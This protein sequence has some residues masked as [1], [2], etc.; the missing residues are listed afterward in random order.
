MKLEVNKDHKKIDLKNLKLPIKKV[1]A[2]AGTVLCLFTAAF[3]KEV[4][5]EDVISNS[6]VDVLISE[7][8][9]SNIEDSAR[10]YNDFEINDEVANEDLQRLKVLDLTIDKENKDL[11]FLESCSNIEELKLNIKDKDNLDLNVLSRCQNLKKLNLEFLWLEDNASLFSFFDFLKGCTNLKELE[12][13]T[14]ESYIN[15]PVELTDYVQNLDKL[16]IS[17]R[18]LENMDLDFSKLHDMTLEFV[19]VEEY[20]LAMWFTKEDYDTLKNNNVKVVFNNIDKDL[21]LNIDEKI[22]DIIKKLGVTKEN[23]DREKLDAILI[24]VLQNLEYD[25]EVGKLVNNNGPYEDLA[26]TFYEGGR[27]Y[28]ALEKDSAICGNYAALVDALF[29]RLGTHTN[30]FYIKSEKH[31]WN[32][33]N[34]DGMFYYLDAT[35]L[36]N[37]FEV[38]KEETSTS[39]YQDGYLVESIS[40]E[41]IMEEAYEIIEKKDYDKLTWYMED[42][43]PESIKKIDFNEDHVPVIPIDIFLQNNAQQQLITENQSTKKVKVKINGTIVTCCVGALVGV[44]ASIGAAVAI[45]NKKEKKRIEEDARRRAQLESQIY[46][47]YN[48]SYNPYE[49]SQYGPYSSTLNNNYNSCS[50]DNNYFSHGGGFK[51]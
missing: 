48:L 51:K 26:R 49:T 22:N 15:I 50:D 24:Y 39:Y 7:D 40:S 30:S 23:T 28:G 43:D 32:I 44:L 9:E 10:Y 13:K 16:T 11:S 41:P 31:V 35:W 36:D 2:I 37:T 38:G 47:P 42:M 18:S 8:F 3:P 12:I 20:T 27:L 5:A 33:I 45:K 6:Q 34:I 29:N 17:C 4:F 14:F 19:D 1:T 46:N 25:E 21:W